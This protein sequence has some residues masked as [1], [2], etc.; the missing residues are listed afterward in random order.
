MRQDHLRC[1]R[2]FA[3]AGCGWLCTLVFC[4]LS[5]HTSDSAAQDST[6]LATVSAQGH[7]PLSQ[8]IKTLMARHPGLVVTYE[9][10]QYQYVGDVEDVTDHVRPGTTPPALVPR[11]GSVATDYDILSN[12]SPKDPQEMIS[13][14]VEAYN[15]GDNPGRFKV[16]RTGD[17]LHVA[18]DRIR[19]LDGVLVSQASLLDYQISLYEQKPSTALYILAR[20]CEE[21][22]NVSGRSVSWGVVPLNLFAN[23]EMDFGAVNEP[24]RDALVRFMSMFEPTLTWQLLYSPMGERYALNIQIVV[25]SPSPVEPDS[26]SDD[27]QQQQPPDGDAQRF[28]G[29]FI[30][31]PDTQ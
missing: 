22:T 5:V 19:N 1:S 6:S 27:R 29:G 25:P 24:A 9:D 12:G 11:E 7:R 23:K 10:V 13:R 26:K 4:G 21:L 2:R 15:S 18:P 14:L 3:M 8:A 31:L 30:R 16:I 28:G 17:V 20:M